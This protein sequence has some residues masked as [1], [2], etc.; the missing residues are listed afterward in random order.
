MHIHPTGIR[1]ETVKSPSITGDDSM[2]CHRLLISVQLNREN[3]ER[4]NH[5]MI[6]LI[7][8]V[9]YVLFLILQW[10]GEL[11]Q[12]V[13]CHIKLGTYRSQG[14]SSRWSASKYSKEKDGRDRTVMKSGIC[15]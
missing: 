9:L 5:S 7:A 4:K 1:I 15:E 12:L 2:Q 6:Q 10:T 14:Q 8:I 11:K 13:I 3:I